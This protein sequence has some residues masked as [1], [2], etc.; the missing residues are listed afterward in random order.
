MPVLAIYCLA[1]GVATAWLFRSVVTT[2]S[3]IVIG[4]MV[5]YLTLEITNVWYTL[6]PLAPRGS[7]Y[8][9][10]LAGTGILAL[11]AGYAV[12]RRLLPDVIIDWRLE[13]KW[14]GTRER[15]MVVILALWLAL[16]ALSIFNLGRIPSLSSV[17]LPLLD[18]TGSADINR[19]IS[20]LRLQ[21]TKS[22]W[23][24][25]A[26]RGQGAI[27]LFLDIGWRYIFALVWL[28]HWRLREIRSLTLALS[29]S[30]SGCVF[31]VASGVRSSVLLAIAVT[32]VAYS[33]LTAIDT[34]QL[35][36]GAVVLF[37]LAVFVSPLSKQTLGNE[38]ITNRA[39][40]T[41][42]RIF[43]G[44]GDNNAHILDFLESGKLEFGNGAILQE[45]ITAAIPGGSSGSGERPFPNRI[46]VLI[47]GSQRTTF[48]ASPTQFGLLYADFAEWGIVL[49]YAVT[50]VGLGIA[51]PAIR[52]RQRFKTETNFA[53]VAT[54]T[55]TIGAW[56][57]TGITDVIVG[58]VLAWLM[59]HAIEVGAG[60]LVPLDDE[61]DDLGDLHGKPASVHAVPSN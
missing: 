15:M 25:G 37:V 52:R 47:T 56:V 18:P 14:Q 1:A 22:Q 31:L 2:P 8:R 54:V 23:F 20:Q 16:M 51:E 48:F 38:T 42:E 36:R 28:R 19:E 60:P 5:C 12:T 32:F 11:A 9:L 34:K 46:A 24:G 10:T 58:V 39:V 17:L 29:I 45:R 59:H 30:A 49:G 61:P 13:G 35:L 21:S 50:G 57:F 40:T 26:Y 3:R 44:N 43:S 55:Y 6:S 53:F 4:P 27:R 7:M 33:L 41:F